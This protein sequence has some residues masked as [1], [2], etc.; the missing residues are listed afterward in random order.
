MSDPEDPRL[1]EP[2][3]D[4][5]HAAQYIRMPVSTLRAWAYGQD[6]FRPVLALPTRG[7]LSFVNL[8]EAFV[9][10]AMRRRYMIAL[11]KIREAIAYVERA[12]QVEHP[13]A[14]QKFKTDGIDLFVQ[15]ALGSLN[16]SRGGQTQMDAIMADLERIE[17]GSD[18][19]PV[20]LFPLMRDRDDDSRRVRISPFVSF[21]KPVISG[22][23]IPTSIIAERFYAG[24][25]VSELSLDYRVSSED[26]E[27]AV[28][29]EGLLVAA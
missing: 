14:F 20:A 25:S 21:G 17:W 6:N 11:P 28:R 8:T 10:H 16:A 12:F 18:E 4:I 9:L 26:I 13:L 2:R 27:E 3:Y 5:P 15:S 22:T 19:R 23:G 1:S 24:E 29:A 7:Y